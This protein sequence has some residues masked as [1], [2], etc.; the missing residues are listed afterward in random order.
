[1][2]DQLSKLE[3]K[4]SLSKED[5]I[6]QAQLLFWKARAMFVEGVNTQEYLDVTLKAYVDAD[7]AIQSIVDELGNADVKSAM[8]CFMHGW[9]LHDRN[10][11]YHRRKVYLH[12]VGVEEK[13]VAPNPHQ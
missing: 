9:L 1:M 11:V 2:Y 3:K 7:L 4:E 10:A 13:K 8:F 6:H 5:K 12:E